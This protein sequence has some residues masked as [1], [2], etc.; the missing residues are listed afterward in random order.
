MRACPA[1]WLVLLLA[2]AA[3]AEPG[4]VLVE[5]RGSPALPALASQVELHATHRASVQTLDER[6]ADPMTYAERAS[7]LVASGTASIVIWIARVD[8]GFLVF[9]AGRWPGRA[10]IELIRVDEAMEPA[11]LER[12]IAL[13]IA[14][15]L[16]TLL[17]PKVSVR[18][19]LG[20]GPGEARPGARARWQIEVTGLVARE[21]HERRLDGRTALSVSRAWTAGAWIFAPTLAAYWQPSGTIEGAG[22]H[23]SLIELGSAVAV[24]AGR[25][26]GPL[27]VFARPRFAV[28]ALLAKGESEDRRRGEATVLAPYIGLEVGARRAIS[29]SAWVGLTIGGELATIHHEFLIDNET[30]LDLGRAR[31]HVGLSLAVSL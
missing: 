20:V 27:Q 12:T 2:R 29:E 28:A 7:Q 3:Y 24:E 8:H 10:M 5:T 6:T 26:L 13:K 19:A 30:I 18:A 9:A 14:G 23:A 4:V 11:E 22:G 31:L 21:P 17:E 25:G 1:A 15:L 16:D